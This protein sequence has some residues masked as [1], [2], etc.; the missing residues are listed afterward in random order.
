MRPVA[1]V[2]GATGF[3]GRHLVA[4]LRGAGYPVVAWARNPAEHGFPSGVKVEPWPE[5][6]AFRERIAELKRPIVFHLASAGVT[7]RN[8]R[9]PTVQFEIN[10][11]LTADLVKACPEA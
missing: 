3:L 11:R 5:P 6:R 7:D 8:R 9:T 10:V 1:L 4:T 2:T